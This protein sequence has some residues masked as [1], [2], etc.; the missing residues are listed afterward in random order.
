MQIASAILMGL[1]DSPLC[2]LASHFNF[3]LHKNLD[4][5]LEARMNKKG[6]R[7]HLAF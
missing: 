1:T 3:S 2:R 4:K 7:D 5:T 6:D